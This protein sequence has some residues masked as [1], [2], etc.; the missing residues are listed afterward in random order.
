MLGAL[1]P[2]REGAWRWGK[3]CWQGEGDEA[4]VA[5]TISC[6]FNE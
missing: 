4:G 3:L 1:S 2:R 6:S 5:D